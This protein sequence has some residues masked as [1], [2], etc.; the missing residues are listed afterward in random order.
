MDSTYDLPR[1]R[2]R[3]RGV[4]ALSDAE[5]LMLLLG[6]GGRGRPV[7]Q[8]AQELLVA[9]RGL[10]GLER[11]GRG[12]LAALPGFGESKACRILAALEIGRRVACRPLP[13]GA[14]LSSSAAVAEALGP[15]LSA[16]ER[17]HFIAIPLDARNRPLGELHIATGSLTAC[18]V[19]PADVFRALLREAAAGVIVVH[20]HP[21]GEPSPSPEDLALTQRLDQAGE[22]LGVRLIDH[23]IVGREGYFSF[24]DAG[25]LGDIAA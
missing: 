21:S 1:E 12:E 16:S 2:L 20:N 6:T 11:M 10:R 8:L 18:P 9:A 25:L 14:K 13:L 4:A 24:V 15:R 23:L 5:L 17:E 19:S 3:R 7:G 22:L